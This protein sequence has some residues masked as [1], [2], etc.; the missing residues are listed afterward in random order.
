MAIASLTDGQCVALPYRPNVGIVLFNEAGLVFA[1]RGRSS[2]PEIVEPGLDWQLPQGGIDEDEDIVAAA[3]RELVEETGI[4][5]ASLLAV[6]S[7]WWSYEFPPYAGP[8]HKLA[9]FRGQRQRWV[10]FRFAGT[11]AEID[12]SRPNGDEPAEFSEWAW[13]PL[14]AMPDRVV[15]FK[16]STYR[17]LARS[18]AEFASPICSTVPARE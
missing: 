18:F 11:E 13:L 6:T 5:S 16:R 8:P 3:R 4:A 2:G 12:I 14:A 10:A 7:E 9:A 1:G 15:S 17:K